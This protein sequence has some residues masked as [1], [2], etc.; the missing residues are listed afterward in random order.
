MS[1]KGKGKKGA[2]KRHVKHVGVTAGLVGTGFKLLFDSGAGAKGG[3]ASAADWMM[4]Q[5]QSLPNRFKYAS[6]AVGAN[7]KELDTY[8]PLIGGALITASKRI[9][10]VGAVARP[11]DDAV[12]RL[13]GGRW[14]L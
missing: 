3:S 6:S 13:T 8:Y 4:N 10:L 1:R 12:A 9:P 14:R 11:V 7:L 5:S 2:R